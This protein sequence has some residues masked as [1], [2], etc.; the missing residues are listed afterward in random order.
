MRLRRE[1]LHALDSELTGE[2]SRG[3]RARLV[4]L[5]SS[6]L[7]VD[8]PKVAIRAHALVERARELTW[9][10]LA[11]ITVARVC[12]ETAVSRRTLE[13]AFA[14]CL[15]IRPHQYTRALGI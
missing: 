7:P 9:A 1:A 5:F 6:A 14:R 10:H 3:V 13:N 15:G 2:V 11:E 8:E 12:E 4:S